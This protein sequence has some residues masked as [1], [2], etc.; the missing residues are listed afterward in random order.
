MSTMP[1]V[2]E[3]L[4]MSIMPVIESAPVADFPSSNFPELASE[5]QA[6]LFSDPDCQG[7][8]WAVFPLASGKPRDIFYVDWNHLVGHGSHDNVASVMVPEGWALTLWEHD[9][10][11]A[12]QFFDVGE[13]QV[14]LGCQNVGQI[15]DLASSLTY[16]EY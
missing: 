16:E 5:N 2:E 6:F 11:G 7:E 3:D 4:P 15:S 8:S 9:F 10:Y 13:N 1:I 14:S 12:H